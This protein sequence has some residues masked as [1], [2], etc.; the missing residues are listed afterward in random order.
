M[1][2]ISSG[3]QFSIVK[4]LARF[5]FGIQTDFK[6][7]EPDQYLPDLAEMRCI[8]DL[9]SGIEYHCSTP[10]VA[11]VITI[12]AP[13]MLLTSSLGMLLVALGIYLGFLWTRHLGENAGIN[14]SRNVFITYITGLVVSA[15]IYN[16]SLLSQ[17]DEKRSEREIIEAYEFEYIFGHPDT[18]SKWGIESVEAQFVDGVLLFTQKEMHATEHDVESQHPPDQTTQR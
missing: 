3:Q 5:I 2:R 16:I 18:M 11:S 10:S 4:G 6:T 1:F 12:S 8:E 7:S 14:D 17:D 15:L 13:Q 9:K